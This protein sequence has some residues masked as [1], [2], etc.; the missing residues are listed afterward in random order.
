MP[1]DEQSQALYQ[2]FVNLI[3]DLFMCKEPMDP[4]QPVDEENN[5][6]ESREMPF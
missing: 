5:P 1:Q 3:I 2:E 4:E 6:S